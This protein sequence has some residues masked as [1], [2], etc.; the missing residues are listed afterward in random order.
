M[1]LTQLR[2]LAA[3]VQS[4][5]NISHAAPKLYKTQP[6]VSKQLK[7]LEDE[8]GFA[9]FERDGRAFT[10]LT[11]GG[12]EVVDQTL[13]IL[14]AVQNIRG[15]SQDVADDG[16]GTLAIGTTGTQARYVL[17]PIVKAF[18]EEYPQVD[19]H[20]HQGT[21]EQVADLVKL[22]R[23]DIAIATGSHELFPGMCLL[24]CFRW[25]RRVV[26][27]KDHPLVA[28]PPLTLQAL[29]HHPIVTYTFSFSGR[30]S[31]PALFESKGL[32][33]KVAFT[34]S[35]A[36]VIKTYV[37]LGLGVGI[38]ASMAIDPKDTDLVALDADHLFAPHLTWIG[39]RRGQILRGYAYE[40]IRML[41]P[42]LTRRLVN[43]AVR[44]RSDAELAEVFEALEI[45][46]QTQ[47]P[48]IV[49]KQASP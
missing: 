28:G 16:V 35:D 32:P 31:L 6:G 10:G 3:V 48:G 24:P 30:S 33:L 22:Q 39:V 43:Q 40:F 19:L 15:M 14:A 36:D 21:A 18:R 47:K 45:P 7:L 42:H 41:G 38:V 26:V 49:D 29:S 37:R 34:A 5:F 27:P 4:D 2:Y 25:N 20:L 17:P 12:R 8:L 1:T 9:L 46:W 23:I 13:K 44:T 11:A